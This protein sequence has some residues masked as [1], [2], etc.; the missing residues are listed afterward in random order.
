MNF[1]T[2]V[3][4]AVGCFQQT[5]WSCESWDPLCIAEI[6]YMQPDVAKNQGLTQL[7]RAA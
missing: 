3:S 5:A 4:I 7:D 1:Y 2:E 6:L